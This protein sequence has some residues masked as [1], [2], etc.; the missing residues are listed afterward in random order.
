MIS[1][2]LKKCSII[3]RTKNEERW[4]SSCLSVV[5]DQTYKN[6]EVIMV[7]NESTDRTIERTKK[8]NDIKYVTISKYL[9]GDALNKGIEVS[10]GDYIV[11]LSGHCIPANKYWLEH[12]VSALEE[13]ENYAGVYG[14]Q[15]PMSFSTP[16]DKRD[17]LLV[18][19]LDRKIQQYDSFFHN[20]NSILRRSLW[21]KLPFDNQVTNIEDR[22]WGQEMLNLGYK[23][24]YEP[25]ASVYHYHGIHQNGNIERCNS[26]VKI[27]QDMQS[28]EISQG[29]LDPN[30]MLIIALIPIKGED[31][32]I[33]DKSQMA[34]TIESALNSKYIDRIIVST[35][36]EETARVAEELGAE[37]P[38]IRSGSLTMDYVSLDAVLKDAVLNLEEHGIYPDLIV[39]LEETFPFR[40]NTLIDDIIN[41]TLNEGFDTVIAAKC[42]SGSLWQ[43]GDKEGFKRLDSGD[44]PRLYKEKSY[45]G[46]KGLC[47]VTHPEFLRQEKLFEGKV[48]LYEINTP[49][50]F[51]E[52]RDKI[53]RET[54]SKLMSYYN[55][56]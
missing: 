36:S 22:I 7:D 55:F 26:I 31:L 13:N 51:F 50:S 53:G 20:A 24:L 9:P 39:S 48:G 18:F 29:R 15:E 42:E 35:N 43:E 30:E 21:D 28:N 49:L 1:E 19:G 5:F 56:G 3:I 45:I 44:T 12:L 52:V 16:S 37:C 25:E 23:L 14:R 32:K 54:A 6:I 4:I 40:E 33:N 47:C 10:T 11:C 41:H 34:F 2:S 27:I 17:L 46:L 8:F 38:F